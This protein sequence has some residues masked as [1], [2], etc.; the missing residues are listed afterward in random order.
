[1]AKRKGSLGRPMAAPTNSVEDFD[2]YMFVSRK[3]PRMRLHPGNF[4]ERKNQALTV[5]LCFAMVVTPSM[6]RTTA[7]ITSI[8]PRTT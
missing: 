1:M 4:T 2:T 8:R 5:F 7:R 6:A 3:T